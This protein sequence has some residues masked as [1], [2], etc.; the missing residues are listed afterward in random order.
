[1]RSALP[2]IT[3]L[4]YVSIV[5]GL[6]GG[7]EIYITRGRSGVRRGCAHTKSA[8]ESSSCPI[9]LLFLRQ[10]ATRP[11]RKSKKRPNGKNARA[12]YRLDFSV[13]SPRQ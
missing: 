11:S 2:S 9:M 7:E 3:L 5:L 4:A 1:M 12:R 13:G 10:R 6:G 8:R